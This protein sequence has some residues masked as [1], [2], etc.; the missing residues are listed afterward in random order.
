MAKAP[1]ETQ[2]PTQNPA[3]ATPADSD[4]V[5][6]FTVMT[7]ATPVLSYSWPDSDPLNGELRTMILEQEKKSAGVVKSNAGGWHSELGLFKW[8]AACVR[9]LQE[10]A[11]IACVELTRNVVMRPNSRFT[12]NFHIDGWANV[13]RSGDYHT[14]HNHPNNL[15]S[16]VY[17]VAV[18]EAEPDRP[19]N[20]M[21][22]LLDPRQS[23]NMVGI[24]ESL[25]ELRY[26]IR[27]S[28]GLMIVFPSWLR[29]YVHPYYGTGERISV[30]FNVLLTDFKFVDNPQS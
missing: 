14:V 27:P 6:K 9:V 23:P 26:T 13:V 16:G 29:H 11:R 17:Y 24:P 1:T 2:S 3:P 4:A 18:G 30:A 7:F 25:F 21:L 12:A 20:G 28:A 19:N 5:R 8:D 22:E 10:R 15:W